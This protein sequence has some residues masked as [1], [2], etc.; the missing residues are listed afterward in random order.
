MHQLPET[1]A[2]QYAIIIDAKNAL[3]L[4]QSAVIADIGL[5]LEL[6]IPKINVYAMDAVKLISAHQDLDYIHQECVNRHFKLQFSDLEWRRSES[7]PCGLAFIHNKR[8]QEF[9]W[10]KK[11][12]EFN[13]YSDAQAVGLQFL[14][15]PAAV[16]ENRLPA[17]RSQR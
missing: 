6:L 15:D 4:R 11:M 5:Y 10:Q 7:H 8:H 13:G 12:L 16:I 2:Y 3:T 1:L 17:L 14:N 9:S